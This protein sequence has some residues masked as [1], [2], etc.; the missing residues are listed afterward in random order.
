MNTDESMKPIYHVI[1]AVIF[2]I[3][4]IFAL[5]VVLWIYE[6]RIRRWM[7]LKRNALRKFQSFP[8]QRKESIDEHA[9]QTR[10]K[11]TQQRR[12]EQK[13]EIS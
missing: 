10:T 1:H 7:K 12:A 4:V 8:K 3:A 9:N 6:P 11:D 2:L 13:D 5:R